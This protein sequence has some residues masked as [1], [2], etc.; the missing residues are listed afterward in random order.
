MSIP[1]TAYACRNNSRSLGRSARASWPHTG[2]PLN[3]CRL[4]VVV[5]DIELVVLILF[6]SRRK[7]T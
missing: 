6:M 4:F 7:L 1:L 5:R 2:Y 3:A